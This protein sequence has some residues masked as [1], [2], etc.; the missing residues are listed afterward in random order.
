M[1]LVSSSRCRIEP[2]REAEARCQLLLFVKVLHPHL[3]WQLYG[4]TGS[5]SAETRG[6]L[7]AWRGDGC[8]GSV[9]GT[10]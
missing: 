8:A 1:V 9:S 5:S 6:V 3:S 2:S 10:Q 7:K 4:V